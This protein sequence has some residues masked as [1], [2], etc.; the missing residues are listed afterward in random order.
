MAGSGFHSNN[1]MIY[2][3][4]NTVLIE[5]IKNMSALLI[6]VTFGFPSLGEVILISYPT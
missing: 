2:H 6:Y 3:F 1:K 4:Q 5:V